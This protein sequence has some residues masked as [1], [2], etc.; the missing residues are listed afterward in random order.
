MQMLQLISLSNFRF[1]LVAP[2]L[3]RINSPENIFLQAEG[4]ASPVE[5]II[6]VTDFTKTT[7][8]F[9]DGVTLDPGND[10]HT[11]KSLQV[12][13]GMRLAFLVTNSQGCI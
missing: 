12:K 8:L 9:T 10:F 5:V 11:L 7:M 4:I 1:T 3:L 6:S 13:A 2:D